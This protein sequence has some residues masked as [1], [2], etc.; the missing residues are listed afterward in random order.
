MDVAAGGAG[1]QAVSRE[2]RSRA[3]LNIV[4]CV[5]TLLLASACVV[6][7]V[8]VWR[9]HDDRQAEAERQEV[10]GDVLEA[11]TTE[12]EAFINIRYDDAQDSI[13]K[14]AAGATGEFRDQYDSSTKGVLEVLEQ[15]KS[16]MD[17]EV[18]WA[19]VVNVDQDNATVIAATTGTVANVST[20]NKP[21]ARHFRLQL[22]LVLED[23][24]W[25]TRDL[26]FVG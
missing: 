12:A 7:G 1:G 3:R 23:G 17:G 24:A 21:V 6:G 10:Y 15:N 2:P 20:D 9:T 13:D 14:V 16:V 11:A 25:L 22:E 18:T 8:M 26:Q 19:G 4:L 5:V